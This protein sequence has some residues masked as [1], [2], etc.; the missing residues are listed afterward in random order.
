M[1]APFV[2]TH[3]HLDDEQFADDLPS[4]VERALAAGVD[5]IITIATT[6]ASS[7]ASISLAM[8]FPAL[9]A[10]VGIQPNNVAEA[11]E[12]DWDKV[13]A[14]VPHYGPD[15]PVIESNRQEE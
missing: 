14:L 7:F 2:D 3:A 4:V 12:G 6:A 13:A 5:R 15:A 8:K 1:P 10:T 9:F 11:A